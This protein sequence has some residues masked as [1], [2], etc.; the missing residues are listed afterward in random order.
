MPECGQEL[1]SAMAGTFDALRANDAL[2]Q[3]CY[4]PE[5]FIAVRRVGVSDGWRVPL[6]SENRD[7]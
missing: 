6:T 1:T 4:K 7:C 2:D 5:A 3:S